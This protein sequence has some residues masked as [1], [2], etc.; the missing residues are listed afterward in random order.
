MGKVAKRKAPKKLSKV[1]MGIPWGALIEGAK[2]LFKIGKAA[3]PIVKKIYKHPITQ[4][5]VVK[6]LKEKYPVLNKLPFGPTHPMSKEFVKPPSGWKP[7][8]FKEIMAGQVTDIKYKHPKIISGGVKGKQESPIQPPKFIWDAR[9]R[10]SD[11]FKN[12][13]K[14]P[15]TGKRP[16]IVGPLNIH[17]KKVT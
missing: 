9:K 7:K 14:K 15:T 10:E 2:Q 3:A 5:K 16:K 1:P 12:F 4:R 6:P 17:T 13:G 8:N 11:H